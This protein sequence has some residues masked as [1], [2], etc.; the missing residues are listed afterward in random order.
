MRMKSCSLSFRAVLGA[1][2]FLALM[3]AGIVSG[4]AA[5]H[6]QSLKAG[7]SDEAPVTVEADDGIE[8]I[9]EDQMYVARG[10]ARAERGGVTVAADTLT[11]LYRETGG[12][13]DI[14]RLEAIGNVV[15]TSEK[16]TGYGRRR[17]ARHQGAAPA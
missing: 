3:A 4:P 13:T 8:W 2:S 16:Q 1:V 12:A 15:I 10:N 6:A 9:R 11:A 5:V 7:N 17:Y 14:Y